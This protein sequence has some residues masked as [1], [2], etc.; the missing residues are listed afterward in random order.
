MATRMATNT[1]RIKTVSKLTDYVGPRQNQ[2]VKIR[3]SKSAQYIDVSDTSNI[4]HISQSGKEG[5]WG[6]ADL[7]V[8]CALPRPRRLPCAWPLPLPCALPRPRRL[9]E[10]W[11]P[12]LPVCASTNFRHAL[13]SSASSVLTHVYACVCI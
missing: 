5:G 3:T 11:P 7:L 4:N 1:V 10:D 9:P 12:P 6:A 2:D 8:P 13:V